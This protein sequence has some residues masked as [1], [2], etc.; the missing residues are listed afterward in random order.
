MNFDELVSIFIV[1]WAVIDPIG[2]IPVF[3][4][5]TKNYDEVE[6][7]S[8]AK[9]STFVATLIL[10]FFLIVGEFILK[11][12][13][14]PLAAFQTSGGVILFLFAMNM[15]FGS[16]KPEEEIQLV[17]NGTETAIFPL[18]IPS[19][20]GPG[21][22]LA[23]VLLADSERSSFLSQSKVAIVLLVIL[24]INYILM[25]LANKIHQRIGNSGAIVI[26]KVMGL[27]LA[28]MA[29]NNILMGIKTFF[30]IA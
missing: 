27:I 7:V 12:V 19:I 3:I 16:S 5:I 25:R 4:A 28:S 13:G 1:L 18:A 14:V 26:S 9:K 10:F 11:N 29:A 21:A 6:K 30:K 24:L 2:T 20:A 23:V 17:K 15:I 22:I 8:I